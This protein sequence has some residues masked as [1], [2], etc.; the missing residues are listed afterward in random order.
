M[1]EGVGG[2]GVDVDGVDVDEEVLDF[3]E[4][5]VGVDEFIEMGE[6]LSDGSGV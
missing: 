2:F 5:E 3:I 4:E 6:G 1:G